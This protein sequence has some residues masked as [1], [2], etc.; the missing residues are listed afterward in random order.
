MR[1]P[2]SNKLTHVIAGDELWIHQLVGTW[3]N[4][5]RE[6]YYK[7]ACA[8]AVKI[9]HS[10]NCCRLLMLTID[11]RL[12]LTYSFSLLA[13][14]QTGT[15]TYRTCEPRE[16]FPS[17]DTEQ[18]IVAIKLLSFTLNHR[19]CFTYNQV[20]QHA[21]NCAAS[22]WRSVKFQPQTTWCVGIQCLERSEYVYS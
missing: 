11:H 18:W 14:R 10:N 4:T 20:K 22:Y 16:S 8:C 19:G 15:W 3:S 9:V 7:C 12:T 1:R 17:F 5:R 13:V 2:I 21:Y 6:P